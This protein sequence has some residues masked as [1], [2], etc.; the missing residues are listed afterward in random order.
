MTGIDQI[1]SGFFGLEAKP[2]LAQPPEND[3]FFEQLVDIINPLQHIPILSNIYRNLTG[4]QM[5][6]AANI[7]GSGLFGG[8][9]AAGFAIASEIVNSEQKPTQTAL[10]DSQ[11]ASNAYN[12]M[13]V[14]TADWLRA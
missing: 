14:T 9:L 8:P 12:K 11:T 5:S 6:G 10:A 1:I 3:G 4:D 13:K 7:L 2:N